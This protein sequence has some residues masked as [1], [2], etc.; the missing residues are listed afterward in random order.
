MLRPVILV[1][2]ADVISVYLQAY[3]FPQGHNLVAN[4]R[5]G[6][7]FEPI[8]VWI[9]STQSLTSTRIRLIFRYSK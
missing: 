2:I 8:K 6:R 9:K 4:G 7:R 1:M 5:Y 3:G